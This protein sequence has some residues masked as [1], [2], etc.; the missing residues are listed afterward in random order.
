MNYS[1]DPAASVGSNFSIGDYSVVSSGVAIGDGVSIGGGVFLW[2]GMVLE[3][4]VVIGSNASFATDV[5]ATSAEAVSTTVLR[6][7][8]RV[9]A[10]ATIGAGLTLGANCRVTPGSVVTRDVPPNAIVA[11]NPAHITG[12]VNT[13]HLDLPG[14]AASARTGAAD[15]DLPV[16]HVKQAALHRLPK[17]VDLR[18]ALSFG[19]VGAHLPFEPKRFFMVY[20]VPSREVRGEHAHKACHQFLVC[21]KGSCGIVV[22]DGQ[23]RDEILL[24]SARVGL[25]I[26][27][28]V[29]GIQYQFSRDAVLLVL[30]S[31]IYSA[32]DYIRNYDEFLRAVQGDRHGA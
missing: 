12:Y 26:P 4:G 22:D 23:F 8:A 31:D 19:E 32:E 6:S 18:G 30:A 27:P 25:H 20:D 2:S 21:V 9:G 17:I 5:E 15:G 13:P 10:N 1:V 7:G 28:M 16:L 14:Q 3:S 24:D 29:W 11:G